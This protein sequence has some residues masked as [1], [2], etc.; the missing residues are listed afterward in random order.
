MKRDDEEGNVNNS[1]IP[2]CLV[3]IL[4]VSGEN[5]SLFL[6]GPFPSVFLTNSSSWRL[7]KSLEPKVDDSQ[8][9][10]TTDGGI[11]RLRL[12]VPA[13]PP[14]HLR[15]ARREEP[16]VILR[17]QRK[18]RTAILLIITF[19]HAVANSSFFIDFVELK[20]LHS[21]FFSYLCTRRNDEM[22]TIIYD[23][24]VFGNENSNYTFET[25]GTFRLTKG[26]KIKQGAQFKVIPSEI[27]Y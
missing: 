4:L 9:R 2:K 13:L 5:F 20:L 8:G 27:N 23:S 24:P 25:K 6:L 10:Q 18:P 11:L 14:E 15:S 22:S 1:I 19:Y 12:T 26:V 21:S 7:A 3:M 17:R 16:P